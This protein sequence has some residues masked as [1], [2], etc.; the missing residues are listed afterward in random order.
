MNNEVK[1]DVKTQNNKV[2]SEREL[3]LEDGLSSVFI[4]IDRAKQLI[5]DT[6]SEYFNS[7]NPDDK[8]NYHKIIFYFSRYRAY[9]ECVEMLICDAYNELQKLGASRW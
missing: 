9:A 8:S 7:Y 3:E 1:T 6:V 2:I 5:D 4:A